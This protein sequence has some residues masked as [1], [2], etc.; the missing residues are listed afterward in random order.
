MSI[1]WVLKVHKTKKVNYKTAC[2]RNKL[3]LVILSQDTILL[4]QIL[5]LIKWHCGLKVGHLA[6]SSNSAT[7]RIWLKKLTHVYTA[8][9]ILHLVCHE[10]LI[11]KPKSWSA[12]QHNITQQ[13]ST[14]RSIDR[15]VTNLSVNDNRWEPFHGKQTNSQLV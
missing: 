6:D 2:P 10:L 7:W 8:A 14:S 1:C 5:L 11:S 3:R 9:T 4:H 12:T 13:N 15:E